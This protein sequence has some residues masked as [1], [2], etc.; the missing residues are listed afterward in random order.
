MIFNF[1]MFVIVFH[2]MIQQYNWW[3]STKELEL[4]VNR[5]ND[6]ILMDYHPVYKKTYKVSQGFQDKETYDFVKKQIIKLT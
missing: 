4:I 5:T 3:S 1:N 2:Y 6:F